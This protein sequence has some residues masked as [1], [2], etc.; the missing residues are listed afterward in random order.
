MIPRQ[1]RGISLSA[2]QDAPVFTL[3]AVEFEVL[4]THLGFDQTPLVLKVPSTGRTWTERRRVED[5]AWSTMG[6]RGLGGPVRP[7]PTLVAMLRLLNAP[8]R[9]VDGRLWLG[10]GVRLV[11]AGGC[12]TAVLATKVDDQFTLRAITPGSLAAEAVACLPRLGPGLG[13]SV[14]LPSRDLDAAATAPDA[15]ALVEAL[16][17][18]GI[19]GDDASMLA[20][21]TRDAGHRGQFGVAGRDSWGRRTRPDDVVGFFDTPHGRYLQRRRD[22][23]HNTLWSTIAPTDGRRLIAAIDELLDQA[24]ASRGF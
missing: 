19:R 11:A 22:S 20:R 21:M 8:S 23:G 14:T 1:E 12:D 24:T 18:R 5:T 13:R 6:A 16:R 17:A 9:E 15:A 2:G 4:W 10:R 7:D 3:S